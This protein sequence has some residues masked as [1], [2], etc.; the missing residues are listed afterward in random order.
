VRR[1]GDLLGRGSQVDHPVH[2]RRRDH[3]AGSA[4]RRPG[5]GEG[6]IIVGIG[7]DGGIAYSFN[8]GRNFTSRPFALPAR[9]AAVTFPDAQHGY[10][11]GQHAMVYR[12]RIVPI[13]YKRQE[14]IAAMAP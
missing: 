10:V 12:Y 7:E 8:G 1:A 11:V 4:W 13:D 2:H 6:K 5:V 9:A 3:L 14:M